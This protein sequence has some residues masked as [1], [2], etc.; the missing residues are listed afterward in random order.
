MFVFMGST[1]GLVGISEGTDSVKCG[2]YITAGSPLQDDHSLD[3][4][5]VS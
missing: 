1:G 2:S 4:L 3:S 5:V